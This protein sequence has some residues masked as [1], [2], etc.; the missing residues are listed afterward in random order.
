MTDHALRLFQRPGR[1]GRHPPAQQRR[2]K[3]KTID[4]QDHKKTRKKKWRR[5]RRQRLMRRR[6]VLSKQASA[7]TATTRTDGGLVS[8]GA[9][10]MI[11]TR[12]QLIPSAPCPPCGWFA[13]GLPPLEIQRQ[14][15]PVCPRRAKA[16]HLIAEESNDIGSIKLVGEVFPERREPDR[17]IRR[18]Y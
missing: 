15:H 6:T 13:Q 7:Y 12:V 16:R 1:Q 4:N 14:L 10:A 5:Q 8:P 17:I 2:C 9:A 18:R 11:R 3:S